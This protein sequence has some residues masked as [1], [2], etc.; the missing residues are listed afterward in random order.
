M[1]WHRTK[2]CPFAIVL[3]VVV[4]H[5]SSDVPLSCGYFRPLFHFQAQ[6][7]FMKVSF[8]HLQESLY[9]LFS[10]YPLILYPME[11]HLL[12]DYMRYCLSSS[13]RLYRNLRKEKRISKEVIQELSELRIVPITIYHRVYFISNM[14]SYASVHLI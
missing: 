6:K 12:F 8:M 13:L 11:N 1:R 7:Y 10:T 3:I 4:P 5:A 2:I 9:G 14:F